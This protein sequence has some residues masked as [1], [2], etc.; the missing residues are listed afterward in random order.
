MPRCRNVY[1]ADDTPDAMTVDWIVLTAS[2]IGLAIVTVAS[3]RAGDQ[4][5]AASITAYFS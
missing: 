2:A 3:V 5:L 4:G 1:E